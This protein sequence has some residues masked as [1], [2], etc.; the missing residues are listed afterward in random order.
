MPNIP[1]GDDTVGDTLTSVTNPPAMAQNGVMSFFS[2]LGSALGQGVTNLSANALAEM[3][4]KS[5]ARVQA[6][7]NGNHAINPATGAN[8]PNAAQ[9]AAN[10][11]FLEKFLPSTM[12]YNTDKSG[13]RTPTGIYYALVAGGII[14]VVLLIVRL[15]RK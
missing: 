1:G 12:L 14:L 7:L 6:M 13:V 3:N 4:A 2:Y 5:T 8:D 15:I 11:T 10:R 9:T